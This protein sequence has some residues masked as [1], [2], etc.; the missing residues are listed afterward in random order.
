MVMVIDN[1]DFIIK[2]RLVQIPYVKEKF[3]CV[4]M[5]SSLV[6]LTALFHPLSVQL[7]LCVLLLTLQQFRIT[8]EL[9]LFSKKQVNSGSKEYLFY[10]MVLR[11][12]VFMMA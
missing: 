3:F 10:F 9:F 12:L 11:N 2:G 4:C 1:I 8:T 5:C 7:L 6:A